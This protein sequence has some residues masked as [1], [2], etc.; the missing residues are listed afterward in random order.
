LLQLLLDRC[1]DP[2]LGGGHGL[3]SPQPLPLFAQF[4]EHKFTLFTLFVVQERQADVLAL[5]VGIRRLHAVSREL[6]TPEREGRPSPVGACGRK[7]EPMLFAALAVQSE[8]VSKDLSDRAQE[9][10]S[11][12]PDIGAY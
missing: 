5:V 4:A 3:G 6:V 11:F 9:L 1:A 2:S 8:V 12:A 7:R 10:A